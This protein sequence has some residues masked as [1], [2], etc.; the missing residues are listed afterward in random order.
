MP[1]TSAAHLLLLFVL[2]LTS[3]SRRFRVCKW[4]YRRFNFVAVETATVAVQVDTFIT[5]VRHGATDMP[6]REPP[7]SS[8]EGVSLRFLSLSLL[9]SL[10]FFSPMLVCEAPAVCEALDVITPRQRWVPQES[11]QL[12]SVHLER[13]ATK[14]CAP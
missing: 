9:L 14:S 8:S 10:D 7:E 6:A 12:P 2:V 11:M 3:L 13:S 4:H 1:A 5:R